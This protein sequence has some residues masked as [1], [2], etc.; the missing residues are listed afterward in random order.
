MNINEQWHKNFNS[1]KFN[2]IAIHFMSHDLAKIKKIKLRSKKLKRHI[3]EV[4]AQK[5][6]SKL[7]EYNDG[8]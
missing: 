7:S 4:K 3:Q 8:I 6:R 1:G 2:L 5:R